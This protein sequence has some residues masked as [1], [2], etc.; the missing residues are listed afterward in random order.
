MKAIV[1]SLS[2]F[3]A[4][5]IIL[6]V[7]IFGMYVSYNNKYV[8]LMNLG[9]TKQVDNK[10]EYDNMWKKISQVA[11][12]SE[13]ERDSLMKIFVEHAGARSSKSD[14]Q[15]MTWVT[16]SIPN[17]SPDLFRNLQNIIVSSRDAWTMRQKELLNIKRELDNLMQMI[18]SSWFL[19]GRAT[20]EVVIITSSK[21]EKSFE[22]G[23]DDDTS[24]FENLERK[25]NDENK[26]R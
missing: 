15:V 9:K 12:V 25:R 6:G 5:G 23:K 14:Q 11:Q 21:T 17:I 13:K 19:S 18:P 24:V 4:A 7:T 16:E 20:L 3:V 26:N 8:S 1:I 22:T 10:N 2:I